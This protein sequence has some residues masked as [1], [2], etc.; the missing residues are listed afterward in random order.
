M[1]LHNTAAA[2]QEACKFKN[3]A[4]SKN[5]R[6]EGGCLFYFGERGGQGWG[7]RVRGRGDREEEGGGMRQREANPTTSTTNCPPPPA[8]VFLVVKGIYA[9]HAQKEC[10]PALHAKK[11]CMRTACHARM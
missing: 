5:E 8:N 7:G 1:G 10:L 9:A 2:K 6:E 3:A 4:R 11:A